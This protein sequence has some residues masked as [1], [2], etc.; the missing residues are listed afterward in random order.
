MPLNHAF[1]DPALSSSSLEAYLNA[2]IMAFGKKTS[3][4]RPGFNGPYA[5]NIDADG[6]GNCYYVEAGNLGSDSNYWAFVVSAGPDGS[7]TTAKDL[8]K[9]KVGD[10]LAVPF[11]PAGDDIAV[12]IE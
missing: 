12:T 6:W 8:R 10:D 9:K 1:G 7:I 4:G 2:D 5:S 3:A 11:T